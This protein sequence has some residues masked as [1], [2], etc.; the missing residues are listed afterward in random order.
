M[1]DTGSTTKPRIL[2]VDDEVNILT[3]LRRMLWQK[4]DSWEMA[5]APGPAEA[6]Q[7]LS[8]KQADVVVSDMRMPGMNGAEL[9]SEVRKLYPETVRIILSGYS[10]GEDIVRAVGPSH[11]FISKPCDSET[12]IDGISRSLK[13]R[14]AIHSQKVIRFALSES[15]IKSPPAKVFD[16]LE[17]LEVQTATIDDIA[18]AVSADLALS[19]QVLRIVN[20]SYFNMPAEVKTIPAAVRLLGID[21]IRAIATVRGVFSAFDGNKAETER[22]EAL[23]NR[24]I[25]IGALARFI[26]GSIHLPERD[27]QMACTAG[28]LAHI[29]TLV[30]ASNSTARFDSAIR[31]KEGRKVSITEAEQTILGFDHTRL[32]AYILGVWGFNDEILETVRF[33]HQPT[34]SESERT[35][36]LAAVHIAQALHPIEKLRDGT[37]RVEDFAFERE[38]LDDIGIGADLERILDELVHA[39]GLWK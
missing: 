34:M 7:L 16:L 4:R 10:E 15:A 25:V 24:S 13:L 38:W 2:F 9:L 33:H 29:G 21:T 35:G 23:S 37:A 11:R 12:L 5:F 26:A 22:L 1:P 32:G 17:K 27:A 18:E 31:F 8:E 3:G 28:L 19:V 6:L 14:E 36:Q 30:L 39:K 20:S